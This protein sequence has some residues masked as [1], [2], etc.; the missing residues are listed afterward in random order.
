MRV[1]MNTCRGVGFSGSLHRLS[2]ISLVSTCER[3]G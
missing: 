3:D 1:P 2:D